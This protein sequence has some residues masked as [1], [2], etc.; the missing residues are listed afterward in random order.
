[1]ALA[2]GRDGAWASCLTSMHRAH[3]SH[4]SHTPR[5]SASATPARVRNQ[6]PPASTHVLFPCFFAFTYCFVIY[7]LPSR[8]HAQLLS[9]PSHRLPKPLHHQSADPC[10][11]HRLVLHPQLHRLDSVTF[12]DHVHVYAATAHYAHASRSSTIPIS[13]P[14]LPVSI[15]TACATPPGSTGAV[16]QQQPTHKHGGNIAGRERCCESAAYPGI[17]TT[18]LLTRSSTAG[19]DGRPCLDQH[20]ERRPHAA[21]QVAS[22]RGRKG[23]R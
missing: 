6:R 8:L 14:H 5:H 17:T 9:R 19:S 4:T 3:T 10:H 22:P 11:A 15:R 16:H 18:D 1:M 12:R 21:A 13:A 20:P 23:R 2:M 7:L